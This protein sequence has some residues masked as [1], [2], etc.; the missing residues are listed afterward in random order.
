[1]ESHL[2]PF[3]AKWEEH[4]SLGQYFCI[5]RYLCGFSKIPLFRPITLGTSAV[6]VCELTYI[7]PD[8]ISDKEIAVGLF[9]LATWELC[10]QLS[11]LFCCCFC[12]YPIS[13]FMCKNCAWSSLLE[14]LRV[15]CA[16]GKHSVFC[17]SWT[18]N[19]YLL[20]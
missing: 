2:L 16:P 7:Q 20:F 6:P 17:G 19:C 3:N 9:L 18:I 13:D 11:V 4:L 14:G 10:A 1:M 8:S 12:Q 15:L 5:F